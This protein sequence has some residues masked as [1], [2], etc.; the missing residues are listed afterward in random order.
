LVTRIIGST[1]MVESRNHARYTGATF[2]DI[3]QDRH[4]ELIV[5]ARDVASRA[6]APYSHF[7][8][9]A[10]V[11]DAHGT[12]YVGCNVES[13][14]YGLTICAERNAIFA[15]IADGAV[16]PFSALAVS[17]LDAA[18]PCMPCGAC[19]QVLFEHL[20]TDAP[21]AVDGGGQF[22]IGQL[23]PHAFTLETGAP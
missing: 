10:A 4:A 13:A 11:E 14:S 21:I 19:R 17:C 12:V 3:V 9:G 23:L 18:G 2:D 5:Q 1:E 8:V 15:A 22:T 16:R 20:A 6:Y 7:R